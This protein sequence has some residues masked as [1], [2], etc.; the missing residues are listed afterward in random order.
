[1]SN[2]KDYR[3]KELRWY[4]LANLFIFLL[5][6]NV[7]NI[8]E[9]ENI[10]F[11]EACISITSS[12]AFSAVLYLYTLLVE[13][14]FSSKTKDFFLNFSIFHL[15]GQK[16]FS[17]IK[18]KCNDYR[19]TQEQVLNKYLGVYTQMPS[20]KKERYSYENARWYEI[21]HIHRE[22]SMVEVSHRDYLL[23]RD[24]YISTLS[25]IFIYVISTRLFDFFP[26]NMEYFIYLFFMLVV[27]N[28]GTY[29]KSKR[30]VYN[31]IALDLQKK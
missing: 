13:S 23:S 24:I 26:F 19:F 28:I 31:V 7:F 1:L 14:L 21:Y 3:E 4:L 6:H 8:Q 25:I 5:M 18:K 9:I 20:R 11:V 29:Q 2:L 10:E 16:V 15:P 30:F 17:T 22:N 27:M 12:I